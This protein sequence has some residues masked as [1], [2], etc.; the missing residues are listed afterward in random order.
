MGVN[1]VLCVSD[2]LGWV[3]GENMPGGR[4]YA[5]FNSNPYLLDTEAPWNMGGSSDAC[6]TSV[7]MANKLANGV[8]ETTNNQVLFMIGNSRG[9]LSVFTME[10]GSSEPVLVVD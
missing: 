5:H 2:E 4:F 10:P 1:R 6:I 9:V 7:W 3:M 8:Y